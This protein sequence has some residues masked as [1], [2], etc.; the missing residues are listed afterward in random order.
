[1]KKIRS[2]CL[3]ALFTVAFAGSALAGDI[4]CG[5][6]GETS[7]PPQARADQIECG[8]L[9]IELTERIYAVL[10]GAWMGF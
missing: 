10:K 4:E 2:V 6:T 8:K 5:V 7:A 3:A 1:M 9:S